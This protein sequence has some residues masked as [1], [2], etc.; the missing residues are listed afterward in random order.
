MAL[1]GAARHNPT[2]CGINEDWKRFA[3][4]NPACWFEDVKEHF[5]T[6]NKVDR[7]SLMKRRISKLDIRWYFPGSDVNRSGR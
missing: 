5:S 1:N 7:V 6:Q 3:Q 2:E 4:L